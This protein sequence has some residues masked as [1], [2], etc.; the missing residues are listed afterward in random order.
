[1]IKR[2][3][4]AAVAAVMAAMLLPA[5]YAAESIDEAIQNGIGIETCN[6]SFAEA[7]TIEGIR[8]IKGSNLVLQNLVNSEVNKS[9]GSPAPS[10]RFY[11]E[12][13]NSQA[14]QTLTMIAGI[15]DGIVTIEGDFRL[16]DFSTV[17]QMLDFHVGYADG[18]EGWVEGFKTTKYFLSNYFTYAG[19]RYNAKKITA[20]SWYKL[21]IALDLGTDTVYY[22]I[23]GEQAGTVKLS[24]SPVRLNRVCVVQKDNGTASSM[25]FDNFSIK[26]YGNSNVFDD[27]IREPAL[28]ERPDKA[29][30]ANDFALGGVHPR[31]MATAS[32]FTALKNEIKTNPDKKQW[33]DWLIYRA[34]E[35]LNYAT[36]KYELRDGVRLMYVA[37]E[38]ELRMATLGMA[39]RLTGDIKYADKAYKDLAAVAAFPDWHPSHHIDVGIMAAG[40]AIGY[41]WLYD[42][43]TNEQRRALEAGIKQNGFKDI[44]ISYRT[45]AGEMTNAAVV[46][47]NHNAMCNGG[48][49]L[50]ALAFYDVYPNESAYIIANATRGFEEMMWHYAPE[51]SWFEGAMYGAICIN[52]LSMAFSS[53]EKCLGTIYGLDEAEGFSQA[54]EY[55]R[56]IESKTA[57]FNF[58]DSDYAKRVSCSSGWICSHF[59]KDNPI[60]LMENGV[61]NANGEQ[62]ALA[63]L[64]CDRE[65]EYDAPRDKL[66]GTDQILVMRDKNALE[67][68]FVGIKAGDTVYDH[69]H[70]DSGSFVFDCQGVRWACDMGK[71]DYNLP[72]Y[73][74][75]SSGRWKIF[76]NR[77]EA[78]NT[79]VVNPDLNPD[80]K[81]YSRA[82]ISGFESNDAGAVAKINMS[83]LL[84]ERLTSANRAFCFTDN[85]KS[86]VIRD[87]LQAD[88]EKDIY[89]LMYTKAN[90]SVDGGRVILSDKASPEKKVIVDFLC[91]KDFD[92][93]YENAAEMVSRGISGQRAN[94]GYYRLALHTKSSGSINVTVKLTPI[95][96]S[97]S[98]VN[99]YDKP[100]ASWSS[101]DINAD[102]QTLDYIP[103]TD[104]PVGSILNKTDFDTNA[105]ITNPDKSMINTCRKSKYG[106]DWSMNQDGTSD[107]ATVIEENGNRICRL[108]ATPNSKYAALAGRSATFTDSTYQSKVG[109]VIRYEADIKF[110]DFNTDKQIFVMKYVNGLGEG[111]KWTPGMLV[112]PAADAGALCISDSRPVL[113]CRIE[114][115]RWYRFASEINMPDACISFFMDGKLVAERRIAN[116]IAEVTYTNISAV[117]SPDCDSELFVDNFLVCRPA[118]DE[119]LFDCYASDDS[120][121]IFADADRAKLITAAYSDCTLLA[122]ACENLTGKN[123]V[124]DYKFPRDST[125][126]AMLWRE[127]TMIPIKTARIKTAG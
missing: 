89:W 11:S 66:Y 111:N 61:S 70:L 20:G 116:G 38:F 81:L 100:I 15:N 64:W 73:F 84:S 60:S 80:Y 3:I 83:G 96:V 48:A 21:K 45:T 112:I 72:N 63:L 39:Y 49:M 47:G 7:D 97:G 23:G 1:M 4:S 118:Y 10:F 59:G 68:T 87:E 78:H 34:D 32:D 98:S 99:D 26:S 19:K 65:A 90:A 54:Y 35:M 56:N 126:K 58:A 71:D 92:I 119:N 109:G 24:G 85:R 2:I 114:P 103:G 125:L 94:D 115:G 121:R 8:S 27:I 52:Y 77:A 88:G 51:G 74:D 106:Y 22:Y 5:A 57:S 75:V 123:E 104:E 95:N 36:L 25:Y 9:V 127:N 62:L 28:S 76:L 122:A 40:F 82:E 33:Y 120:M 102:A 124:F 16:E 86:L 41:D 37:S 113:L 79:I 108:C 13:S 18:S 101:D 55:I 29:T 67:E 12:K 44:L 105:D 6:L 50:A 17:R 69:S 110:S 14:Q 31:I 93:I 43:F 30:V 42:T 107:I 53:M 117:Y 46:Q 91:N